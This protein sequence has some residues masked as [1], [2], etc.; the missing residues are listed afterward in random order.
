MTPFNRSKKNRSAQTDGH[1]RRRIVTGK[2]ITCVF[3]VIMTILLLCGCS[4]K[5]KNYTFTKE[6][7]ELMVGD[8]IKLQVENAPAELSPKDYE[9]R[10]SVSQNCLSVEQDGTVTALRA[11]TAE[12]LAIG[13]VYGKH[14]VS[15]YIETWP[16]TVTANTASAELSNEHIDLILGTKAQDCSVYLKTE[17]PFSNFSPEKEVTWT[18]S[19]SSV[20]TVR[21]NGN[22]SRDPKNN[23][24]YSNICSN[25]VTAQ[26]FGEAV[27]T[28]R[29]GENEYQCTVAVLDPENIE[30]YR[31]LAK[32][33]PARASALFDSCIDLTQ[34]NQSAPNFL[35]RTFETPFEAV[36]DAFSYAD[37]EYS[38]GAHGWH[39]IFPWHQLSPEDCE[40]F[41][42]ELSMAATIYDATDELPLENY[43]TILPLS[44]ENIA[45]LGTASSGKALVIIRPDEK[46]MEIRDAADVDSARIETVSA[47]LALTA[48]LGK[49]YIP[50]SLEEVEYVI[51]LQMTAVDSGAKY[52]FNGN[53]TDAVFYVPELVPKLYHLSDGEWDLLSTGTAV[54]GAAPKQLTSG[55]LW[56]GDIPT[57]DM[58]E[59]IAALNNE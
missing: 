43:Q 49:E 51:E 25:I 21:E 20:F 8:T 13:T 50:V 40:Q 34:W 56:L 14:V 52:T 35:T 31:T 59:M 55:G 24:Y 7:L 42:F 16:V 10:I 47:E 15:E 54:K 39:N 17:H 48:S 57:P 45:L 32:S 36:F 5:E 30:S 38:T 44:E 26:G 58:T 27:L 29:Y 23:N 37:F 1:T 9:W 3:A 11:G 46:Y 19:N 6:P 12:V 22:V 18:S 2:E 41:F 28:A 33:S 4:K 53:T